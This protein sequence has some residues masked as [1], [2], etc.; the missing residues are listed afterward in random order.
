MS[1]PAVGG[2]E[3]NTHSLVMEGLNDPVRALLVLEHDLGN[4]QRVGLN[5]PT[6]TDEPAD[7]RHGALDIRRGGSRREVLRHDHV[8]TRQPSDGDARALR[9]LLLL[10]LLLLVSRR[11]PAH[12]VDLLLGDCGRGRGA[13][14]RVGELR[15]A[16][17]PGRGGLRGRGAGSVDARGEGVG[18]RLTWRRGPLTII[19]L[20][21]VVGPVIV[22]VSRRDARGGR[23]SLAR[24]EA[25]IDV[26][27]ENH[28]NGLG[29]SF[30]L[31]DGTFLT[32]T[33]LASEPPRCG[34]MGALDRRWESLLKMRAA[35]CSFFFRS[36][37]VHFFS[38]RPASVSRISCRVGS[39]PREVT[40]SVTGAFRKDKHTGI[41]DFLEIGS[42]FLGRH[43]ERV[44][45]F[46]PGG[47]RG[48]GD[49]K[50]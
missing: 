16:G 35:S 45:A 48:V 30:Q 49:G 28:T 25:L 37:P 17:G 23:D 15:R 50:R 11:W 5:Q 24:G 44:V 13:C 22:R 42:M 14:P 7:G 6:A 27:V 31:R 19:R 43:V 4:N 47:S 29:A 41:D 21:Q 18:L 9:L 40:D 46:E 34:L 20:V 10:L 38:R 33:R 12:V 2:R 3:W 1:N 36:R 32:P 39:Q 8:G 26:L